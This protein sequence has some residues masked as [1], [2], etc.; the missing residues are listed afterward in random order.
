MDPG[1]SPSATRGDGLKLV[2]RGAEV[3]RSEGRRQRE[4]PDNGRETRRDT[5]R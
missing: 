1:R 2:P 4:D 3:E 5:E